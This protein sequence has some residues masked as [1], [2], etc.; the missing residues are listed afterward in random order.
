MTVVRTGSP[1]FNQILVNLFDSAFLGYMK[2]CPVSPSAA[3]GEGSSI[4]ESA[5]LI[6]QPLPAA[7]AK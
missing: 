7:A 2:R 5:G 6:D 1:K 4:G 3:I